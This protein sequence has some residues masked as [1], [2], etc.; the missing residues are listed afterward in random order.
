MEHLQVNISIDWLYCWLIKRGVFDCFEG[1]VR[2][3]IRH[4]QK[5]KE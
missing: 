3:E 1:D 5:K 4:K 2:K